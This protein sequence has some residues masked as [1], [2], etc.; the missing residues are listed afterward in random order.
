MRQSD[1]NDTLAIRH[2]AFSSMDELLNA[3]GGYR[4]SLNVATAEVRE[5]ADQY[6]YIQ[7]SLGDPRRAARYS[8]RPRRS[9]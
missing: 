7:E 1:G 6:D 9:S 2:T 5:L 3:P 8:I 4:P